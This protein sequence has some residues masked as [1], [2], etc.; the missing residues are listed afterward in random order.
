MILPSL[1]YLEEL[2]LIRCIEDLE[3]NREGIY[4]SVRTACQCIWD[5]SLAYQQGDRKEQ[6]CF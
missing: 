6:C 2:P 3:R 4:K 5:V 1:S